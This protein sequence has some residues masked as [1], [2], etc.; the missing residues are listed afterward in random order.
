MCH[1]G[2]ADS[3]LEASISNHS[4][5]HN[6]TTVSFSPKLEFVDGIDDDDLDPAMKEE[7]DR[8]IYML[9]GCTN[10]GNAQN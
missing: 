1:N 6:L 4:R 5:M 3:V 10:Q 9:Y 2:V 8:Y 7:L